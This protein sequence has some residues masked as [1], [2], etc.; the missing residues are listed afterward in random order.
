MTL[1]AVLQSKDQIPAALADHY[2]EI[3]GKFVLDVPG[4]KTQADFDNYAEALK[5]RFTDSATDF[6]RKQGASLS[7]DDVLEVVTTALQK[8]AP[9][10][11]TPPGKGNT[12]GGAG[13][14]QDP[15]LSARLHDLERNVASLKEQNDTLVKERDQAVTSS[16]DTTIRNSLTEA[17]ASAG[18]EPAGVPNLVS[19]VQSNFEIA[20]DGSVVTKLNGG[21]GVSP[22]QKPADYFAN[23]ARDKAFRMFWPASVG[24]G[25]DGEGPSGRG[26]D[27]GKNNP[28]TKAGWNLTEQGKLFKSNRAEAERLMTAAGVKLGATAPV[29]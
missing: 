14:G 19:L 20:Q 22:N 18:V 3:D 10:G 26:S 23:L 2:V 17:A 29:R 13:V 24:A 1:E 16:R 5:K 8:F 11:G 12:G 6:A 28:W 7:R 15:E 21:K 9:N 25:A 27:T 4:M